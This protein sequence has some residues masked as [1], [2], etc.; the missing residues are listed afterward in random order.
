MSDSMR[1]PA[2]SAPP[3]TWTVH[4]ENGMPHVA[5]NDRSQRLE[6]GTIVAGKYR[7]GEPIGRGAWSTTYA[8]MQQPIGREVAI[9]IAGGET[10]DPVLRERFARE[11]RFLAQIDH[12]NVVK[13]YEMGWLETGPAAI[14]MER[15][16]GETLQQRLDRDGAMAPRD[17]FELVRQLLGAITE[18][19]AR[20]VVHRDLKPTNVFL[21]DRRGEIVP[22]LLDFGIG[23][24]LREVDRLTEVGRF[25]GSPAYLAPEQMMP[26]VTVDARADLYT[27]GVLLFQTLTGQLPF[28]GQGPRVIMMVMRDAP[29]E[30]STL[31]PELGTTVDALIAKALSKKPDDRFQTADEMSE[32]LRIATLAIDGDPVPDRRE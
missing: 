18:V 8:A 3:P 12:P 2:S 4:D 28:V 17:A 21:A 7:L 5:S 14:V 27:L 25:V 31:R 10:G 22:R 20:A 26:Q 1:A 24:D 15:M 6:P 13:V 9:K 11:A 16:H 30:P 19:H 23:R 32:A 29:P